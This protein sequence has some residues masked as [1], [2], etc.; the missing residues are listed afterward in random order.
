MKSSLKSEIPDFYFRPLSYENDKGLINLLNSKDFLGNIDALI[1]CSFAVANSILWQV[2]IQHTYI[3][4]HLAFQQQSVTH[5]VREDDNG[6]PRPAT[7]SDKIGMNNSSSH[8][9]LQT[10]VCRGYPSTEAPT[11]VPSHQDHI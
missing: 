7:R 9:V 2:D 4:C 5:R 10:S 6:S 11:A 1:T 8:T 3:S